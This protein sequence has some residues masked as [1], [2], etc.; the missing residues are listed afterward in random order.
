MPT[1]PTG[2][3]GGTAVVPAQAALPSVAELVSVSAGAGSEVDVSRNWRLGTKAEVGYRAPT[4]SA[5]ARWPSTPPPTPPDAVPGSATIPVL[6]RQ[7][8]VLAEPSATVRITRLDELVLTTPL[9]QRWYQDGTDVFT[10]TPQLAWQTRLSRTGGLRLA[11]GAA[12]ARFHGPPSSLGS[13]SVTRP[14]GSADVSG[15]L[16]R[17]SGVTMQ[18][19]AELAVDYFVDPVLGAL[20]SR[21]STSA[22]LVLLFEP[23]WSAGIEGAFS[24]DLRRQPL[25]NNGPLDETVAS[26]SLPV[27]YRA[28]ENLMIEFGGRWSD[29]APL[30]WAQDAHFHQRQLWAYC[31]LTWTTRSTPKAMR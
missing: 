1:G 9:S 23:D 8:S 26:A 18:G 25:T 28:S 31:V 16:T 22:R 2:P 30:L 19:Q 10:L 4:A 12:Y 13:G 14:V 20:G 5:W 17:L 27:R 3:P 11:G 6:S 15:I 24:S 29:R 21:A 7:T